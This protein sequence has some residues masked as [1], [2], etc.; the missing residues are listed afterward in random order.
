MDNIDLYEIKTNVKCIK[1]NCK[2]AV[3]SYGTWYENGNKHNNEPHLSK[4]IGF[5]GTIPWKC[6]NCGNTGLIDH[7]GLECYNKA[8][9]TIK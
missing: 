4:S 5:G 2:G 3:H 1:C 9:E 8:F 7:S 6:I